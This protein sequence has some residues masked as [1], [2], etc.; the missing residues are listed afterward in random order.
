MAERPRCCSAS[1]ISISPS[2]APAPTASM[3]CCGVDARVA[4]PNEQAQRPAD[5]AQ[6][7][8]LLPAVGLVVVGLALLVIGGEALVRAATTIAEL[9]GLTPAVI[10]LTVVAIGTS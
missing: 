5:E 3:R 8:D 4:T 7:V 2:L 10:G 9:A 6:P 1:S